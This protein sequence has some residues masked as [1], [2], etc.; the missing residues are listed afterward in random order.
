MSPKTAL[1]GT[2][3]LVPPFVR[4]LP[5]NLEVLHIFDIGMAVH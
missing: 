3:E 4:D 2:R 1:V 5:P